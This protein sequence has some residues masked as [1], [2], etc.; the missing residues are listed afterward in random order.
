VDDEREIRIGVFICDCGGRIADV[1]DVAG[2][3]AGVRD[4]PRVA[5]TQ[6]EL[7]S[8]SKRGLRDTKE[9]VQEYGLNRIVIAGCTP[10]THGLLFEA[11]LEDAGLNGALFEMANIREQCALVHADDKAGATRK[12]LDL[13][14][15]AVAKAALVEP[16][17]K[18]RIEVTPTALV[19]GG[20]IAGLTAALTVAKA[21]FP[22]K[23]LD[24][25]EELGGLVG[26]LYTLYPSDESAREYIEKRIEAV[27]EHPAIE[28]FTGA[29]LSG[30]GGSAGNYQITV[31]QDGRS[32]EFNVGAIIVA[33][34]AQ[35]CKPDNMFGYDGRRVITQLEL[36][37]ALQ[38]AGSLDAHR[39]VMITDGMDKP[40]Y[41]SIP[42]ASVLKN[43]VLL[44]RK[45]PQTE[46]SVLFRNLGNDL[47]Q[48]KLK[49]ATD[50]GVHF[51]RYDGMGEPQVMEEVVEVYDQLRGEELVIPHDLVVLA[52][53]LVPQ[54]DGVRISSMLRIPL[55]E[56]GFF[57]EPNMRLRPG[58]YVDDGV[59]VCGSAHYPADV[60]ESEFQ[61]YR[62][63]AKALRYLSE[64]QIDS[65]TAPA[66]VLENLCTGCGSCVEACPFQAVAM[67]EREGALS[68]SRID[69]LLCKR[70]GNCAVVC[71]VKAIVM[72]PYTDRELI[73]QIDA[74][75]R[76]PRG[77]E[78]RILGLM[79]E[80][81]GYAAADLAG[82]E[83]LQ[84]PS[85]LRIISLGCSARV[86]PYHILWAFLNGA[87]GILLGGCD[88]GLC[89]YV[90]GNQYAEHRVE[91]L[92]KM[93]KRAG[94]DP[95]RLRLQ[96]FRPD[97]ARKFVEVVREFADE[98]EYL[99]PTDV[100]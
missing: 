24:R 28:I 46:V 35:E 59:F 25:E 92:Q 72:E 94:F 42:T 65:D 91:M 1:I 47:D 20:G 77:E 58:N 12:A 71:P 96:W 9:A 74:A 56:N 40:H 44:K 98:M 75:L 29:E 84:Y 99:E 8:C 5:L 43:S 63:A 2:L 37:Q 73:A 88:P 22:V 60:R 36:E 97:D 53:P 64:E 3:E 34:G 86:D 93:L 79:C 95:R 6:R 38:Q 7:Y 23:L 66:M 11:A 87:D 19:L 62:A 61:A 90:E 83:E 39:V 51:V 13:I 26:K 67:D 100:D 33:T 4:M 89:H 18:M 70:C 41:S 76:A 80:W 15:M 78:P 10:R 68:V 21:G 81:S 14:R 30:F 49:E 82:A 27:K 45:N 69:P 54:A 48:R 85:N 57:L 17:E 16:R 55:D 50:L 52:M 32:S 31:E